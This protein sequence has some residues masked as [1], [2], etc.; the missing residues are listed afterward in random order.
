MQDTQTDPYPLDP[1]P[2]PETG[3][4]PASATQV[5]K[6]V[7]ITAGR[8]KKLQ[9]H[10]ASSAADF[11]KAQVALANM[12]EGKQKGKSPVVDRL[13]DYY[14]ELQNQ[15]D[16]FALLHETVSEVLDTVESLL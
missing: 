4:E 7:K 5:A 14:D 10:L 6:P 1:T 16:G 13:F 2:E 8:L 9:A 15:S 11:A 3:V 12:L